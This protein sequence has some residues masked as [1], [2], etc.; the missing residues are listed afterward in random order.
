[1]Q[2]LPHR[3]PPSLDGIQY[4]LVVSYARL[5]CFPRRIRSQDCSQKTAFSSCFDVYSDDGQT[6][7]ILTEVIETPRTS[8]K[9]YTVLHAQVAIDE[10]LAAS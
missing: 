6:S 8:P 7:L 4:Q 2:A 9:Y 5:P 3:V 10:E 1:M